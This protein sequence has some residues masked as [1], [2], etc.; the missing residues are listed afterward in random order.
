MIPLINASIE[1][2]KSIDNK[3]AIPHPTVEEHKY[4]KTV[5]A[6]IFIVTSSCSTASSS[7]D[8][9]HSLQQLT[10]YIFFAMI[11]NEFSVRKK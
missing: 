1:C 4:N 7:K 5:L 11:K 8:N 10:D 6:L 9:H 2:R 3:I